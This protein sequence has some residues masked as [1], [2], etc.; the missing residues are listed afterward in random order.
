M[1]QTGIV[2]RVLKLGFAPFAIISATGA[3]TAPS[4][5]KSSDSTPKTFSFT[6]FV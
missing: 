4:L 3:L 6:Q 2:K 1:K 5:A